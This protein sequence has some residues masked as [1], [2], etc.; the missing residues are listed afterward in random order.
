M[1]LNNK[2]QVE[3]SP[4]FPLHN[5]SKIIDYQ[6][7]HVTEGRFRIR[8]PQV[9]YNSEYASKLHWLVDSL[10]FITSVRINPAASSL[11][12]RYEA[13]L[14][15]SATVQ[16]KLIT[17]IQ[18]AGSIEIP[19]EATLIEQRPSSTVNSW[20]RLSLP[21]LGL[22]FALLAGPFK[23]PIPFLL[24]SGLI[25]SAA[26]PIFQR[27]ISGIVNEHKF[28]VDILDSILIVIQ[29]L[30]REYISALIISL[31]ELGELMRDRIDYKTQYKNLELL[32]LS[33]LSACVERDGQQQQIPL[34][35]VLK[36]D[37][38]IVHSG[39][40]ILVNGLILHGTA[41]IDKYNL[42]GEIKPVSC[43]EGQEVLA[44]T[45][46]V[47]GPISLIAQQTG[48]E[49][50]ATLMAE[51]IR[52]KPMAK[53]QIGNQ[54]LEVSNQLVL[55]TLL[56]SGSIF[57]ITGNSPRSLALLQLDFGSGIEIAI[58]TTILNAMNLLDRSNIFVHD[59]QVLEALAHTNSVIFGKTGTL[60]EASATVID[61]Q[62]TNDAATSIEELLAYAASVEQELI[63]PTARAIVGY[64]TEN[65]IQPRTCEAWDYQIGMG[66]TARIDGL[67]IL[68]GSSRFLREAGIDLDLVHRQ[69]P[70][71]LSGSHSLVYVARDKELMGVILLDNPLRKESAGIIA[72]LRERGIKSS[73][74]TG[75]SLEVALAIG[76][77]L[78]ISS[79]NIYAEAGPKQK[80]EIVRELHEQGE[81]VAYIAHGLSDTEALTN[82]DISICFA[83][84]TELE[85]ETADVIILGHDLQA[86]IDVI[87]VAKYTMK[88][89]Y[90]NIAIVTVPNIGIVIAGII[91]GLNPAWAE[92]INNGA[93][94]VA[95]MNSTLLDSTIVPTQ[96]QVESLSRSD[97]QALKISM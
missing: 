7:V 8:V 55:P 27:A 54:I 20:E 5:Q 67:Q 6:V 11:I 76:E 18:Q 58:P 89:V 90:Q 48:L 50:H 60:T 72:A 53:T 93:A 44:S 24:V 2:S 39:E 43:H 84:K 68:V 23:L 26:L 29:V 65:G 78:G 92:I 21:M 12:V 47:K 59:G 34:K 1:Q 69:H 52:A 61:I 86:V 71:L 46:V 82:A 17:C 85:R 38:I 13:T 95:Q 56:M 41:L 16:Q 91:L 66:I 64:A 96:K 3:S 33:S 32:D 4:E 97:K 77:Q 81:T 57:A 36:G 45:K 19:I 10:D 25:I 73:L 31:I 30:L 14:I 63:H 35:H 37:K 75:D 28:N 51:F 88:L 42:T 80:A 87:D 94:I 49:A 74:V 22:G 62:T 15:I 40:M 83:K 70:Q 9:A 79:N